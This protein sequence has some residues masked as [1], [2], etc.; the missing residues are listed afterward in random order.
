MRRCDWF[1]FAWCLDV[2]EWGERIQIWSG[3]S[4]FVWGTIHTVPVGYV[5]SEIVGLGKELFE[6]SLEG[7]FSSKL[8]GGSDGDVIRTGVN[9]GQFVVEN[10]GF[11]TAVDP[12]VG[13]FFAVGDTEVSLGSFDQ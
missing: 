8:V 1:W 6:F 9:E 4:G 3:E 13:V 7:F 2:D 10:S 5:D 12:R 11:P